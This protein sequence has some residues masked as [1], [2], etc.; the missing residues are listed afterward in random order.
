MPWAWQGS[1]CGTS[2]ESLPLVAGGVAV[3]V[4]PVWLCAAVRQ[5]ESSVQGILGSC[6]ALAAEQR[7]LLEAVSMWRVI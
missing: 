4:A 1:W 5:V 2:A 6:R 3:V 7:P